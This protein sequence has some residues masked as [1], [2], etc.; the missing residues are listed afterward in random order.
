MQLSP[1]LARPRP[2]RFFPG[3]SGCATWPRGSAALGGMVGTATRPDRMA[4]V[5]SMV[6]LKREVGCMVWIQ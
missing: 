4:E 1:L 6:D 3:L 2:P 5:R